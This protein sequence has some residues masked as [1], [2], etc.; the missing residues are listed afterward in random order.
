MAGRKTG[1]PRKDTVRGIEG[2]PAARPGPEPWAPTAEQAEQIRSLAAR[3]VAEKEIAI[4]I[5][6]DRDTL[7][8]RAQDHIDAGRSQGIA[9]ITGVLFREA[10]KGSFKHA[11]LYLQHVG[12]WTTRQKVEHSGEGG[13]PI[14]YTILTGVPVPKAE[15][16]EE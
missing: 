16:D 15:A 8:L 3:G 4:L 2:V 10:Q 12:K 13:G 5:G 7:K 1:E 14:S 6:V 9:T 11:A